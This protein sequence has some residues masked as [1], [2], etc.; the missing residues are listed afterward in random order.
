MLASSVES[1]S[2]SASLSLRESERECSVGVLLHRHANTSTSFLMHSLTSVPVVVCG[3]PASSPHRLDKSTIWWGRLWWE[4]RGQRKPVFSR[5]Y[6]LPLVG[7]N[8]DWC[9]LQNWK[10]KKYSYE[11]DNTWRF[12]ISHLYYIVEMSCL[13]IQ[14]LSYRQLPTKSLIKRPTLL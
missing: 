11:T 14:P 13:E 6:L 12:Y 5:L 3:C 7:C 2:E 1:V 4:L 8:L 10:G 9:N